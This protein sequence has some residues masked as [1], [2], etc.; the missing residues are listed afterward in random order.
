MDAFI[1]P[2]TP[3]IEPTRDYA[4]GSSERAAIEAELG[5]LTAS[6]LDLTATIGGEKVSGG[7]G[8]KFGT[9]EMEAVTKRQPDLEKVKRAL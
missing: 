5:L 2:P 4:P 7:G 3:V 6:P 9:A 1:T 8:A